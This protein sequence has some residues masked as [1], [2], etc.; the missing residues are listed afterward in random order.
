MADNTPAPDSPTDPASQALNA[1]IDRRTAKWPKS[2]KETDP[3]PADPIARNA[4]ADK[5]EPVARKVANTPGGATK[6]ASNEAPKAE[7]KAE[8]P[9]RPRYSFEKPGD[10]KW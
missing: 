4:W 5:M 7:E 1:N 8:T 9:T 6:R 3:G 2:V 10:V